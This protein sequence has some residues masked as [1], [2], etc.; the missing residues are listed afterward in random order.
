VSSLFSTNLHIISIEYSNS[1]KVNKVY[2]KERP[3]E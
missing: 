3:P 1:I 2:S